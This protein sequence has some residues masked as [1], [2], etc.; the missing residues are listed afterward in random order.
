MPHRGGVHCVLTSSALQKG[1]GNP[2]FPNFLA[3]ASFL[4]ILSVLFLFYL[5]SL[6][7]NHLLANEAGKLPETPWDCF[8]SLPA[9]TEQLKV[10]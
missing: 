3:T 9:S 1:L 5:I 10:S 4:L 7:S 8:P 6:L 2:L